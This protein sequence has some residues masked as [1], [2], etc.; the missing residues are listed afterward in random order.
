MLPL[1]DHNPRQTTPFVNYVLVAI[2]VL[3]FLW[4]VSLGPNIER[5]LFAVSFVPFLVYFMLSW[6]QHVRSATVMPTP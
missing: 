1:S 4:E 2:N 3:M 5:T 6:Q